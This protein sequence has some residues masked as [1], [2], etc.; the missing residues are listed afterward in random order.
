[1]ST[2]LLVYSIYVPFWVAI[3]V[4][5]ICLLMLVAW[6]YQNKKKMTSIDR[7]DESESTDV[8]SVS[9]DSSNVNTPLLDS[10]GSP[11]SS[12]PHQ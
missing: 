10:S 12:H 6:P 7:E 1:M 2:F 5:G 11:T 8:D 4:D 9:D 3:T